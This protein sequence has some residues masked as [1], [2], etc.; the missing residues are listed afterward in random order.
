MVR[1]CGVRCGAGLGRAQQG[2]V[3]CGVVRHGV[4]RSGILWFVV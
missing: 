4:V 1:Y 2:E 3:R